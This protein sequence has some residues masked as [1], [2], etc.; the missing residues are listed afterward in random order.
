VV[1]NKTPNDY[2]R[3]SGALEAKGLQMYDG[4]RRP[5]IALCASWITGAGPRRTFG[6][7]MTRIGH[8]PA[9]C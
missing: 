2:D 1:K 9:S 7:P 3:R 6:P 8:P 4:F 5:P